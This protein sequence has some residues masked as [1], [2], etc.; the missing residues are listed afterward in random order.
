MFQ[1]DASNFNNSNYGTHFTFE[2]NGRR[3]TYCYIQKNACTTFKQFFIHLSPY[4]K[5]KGVTDMRHLGHFHR[6]SLEDVKLSDFKIM[7]FRDPLDRVVSV[8]K[9]KFVQQRGNPVIFNNFQQL[10]GRDPLNCSFEFF[11]KEYLLAY[12]S[13]CDTH[14]KPQKDHLYPVKYNA[15]MMMEDVYDNMKKII[16][17]EL[18]LEFF[19]KRH[20]ATKSDKKIKGDLSSVKALHLSSIY[21]DS[22]HFPTSE[23]LL[24]PDLEQY[25]KEFYSDDYNILASFN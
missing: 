20:N 24:T 9:N 1:L 22:G 5:E 2:I 19:K 23:S 6:A 15:C 25:I 13:K 8:F 16:G 21:K 4:A 12:K 17:D 11:V 10:T 14:L 3:I 18:A 7:V